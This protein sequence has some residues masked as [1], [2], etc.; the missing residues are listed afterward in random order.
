M[1]LEKISSGDTVKHKSKDILMLVIGKN[2]H[3]IQCEF[4]AADG[5]RIEKVY[6]QDFLEVVNKGPSAA[7]TT[8]LRM[9]D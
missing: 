3:W 8:K 4:S 2:K 5:E 6:D 7:K 1:T 9:P